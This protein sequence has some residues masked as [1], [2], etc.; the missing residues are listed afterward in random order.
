MKKQL[1]AVLVL[2]SF[3]LAGCEPE[4][5]EILFE[6]IPEGLR[7]CKFFYLRNSNKVAMNI[8]RCPLS[9]TTTS[10][11]SGKTGVN[12]GTIEDPAADIERMKRDNE[13]IARRLKEERVA[14]IR[15]KLSL[16][17]YKLITGKE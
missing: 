1:I 13:M 3:L 7:D 4:E 9:I 6:K 12:V 16:E 2:G 17:E 8:V 11:K 15:K 5:K 14:E 10:Y